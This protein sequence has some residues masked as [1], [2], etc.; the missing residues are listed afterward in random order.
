MGHPAYVDDGG[1]PAIGPNDPFFPLVNILNHF[2]NNLV[3]SS[4]AGFVWT[5]HGAEAST[6]AQSKFGGFSVG[7]GGSG[8]YLDGTYVTTRHDWFTSDFTLEAWVYVTTFVAA[9]VTANTHEQSALIGNMQGTGASNLW[10]FG[11]DQNGHL[12]F[13]YSNGTV[14]GFSSAA[15]IS[16]NTWT[17][18]A[19]TLAGTTISLFIN[20]TLDVNSA[21][22]SGT[23]QSSAG[24]P[25]TLG[26]FN[27]TTFHTGYVDDLR[28]TKGV[29]RYKATF[30][31]PTAA[32]PNVYGP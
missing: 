32:F 18:I 11:P 23:P 1:T 16:L 7:A 9:S 19:M 3:D 21:T 29:A 8:N 26:S 27:T 17:H 14:Q 2:D 13:A 15:S 28:L 6:S 12:A 10:S 4:S 24:T 5:A 22:I 31:V 30:A 25:M 20:G